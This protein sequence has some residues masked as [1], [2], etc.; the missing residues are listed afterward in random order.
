MNRS[1]RMSH[2]ISQ[3]MKSFLENLEDVGKLLDIHEEISGKSPGRKYGVEVLN[4]S[5]VVM[6]TAC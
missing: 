5:G 6:T 2:S 3:A 4:K 1:S